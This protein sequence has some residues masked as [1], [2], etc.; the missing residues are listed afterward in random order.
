MDGCTGRWLFGNGMGEAGIEFGPNLQRRVLIIHK[1]LYGL[2]SSGAAWRQHL[3]SSIKS[4]GF[5]SPRGNPDLYLRAACKPDGTEYYEYLLVYVDDILCIS[6]ATA[7]IMKDLVT[8]YRLKE[9]SI[10][11][12]TRY[13]KRHNTVESSTFGSEFVALRVAT[14][15]CQAMRYKLRMFGVT[16]DGPT[17]V[18]CD[19]QLVQKNVSIPTSQLGKINCY[20]CG[21]KIGVLAE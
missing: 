3:S 5:K 15:M 1:A 20:C 18:M 6:H 2:K 10:G 9:G 19:N 11:P 4:L 13:S 16:I 14:E 8:Q 21:S 7:P 12:P 17:S